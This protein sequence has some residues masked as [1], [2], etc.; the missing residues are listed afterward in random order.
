MQP[1]LICLH[2]CPIL[3]HVA[4]FEARAGGLGAGGRSSVLHVHDNVRTLPHDALCH[5]SST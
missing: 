3:W 5:F 2:L 4:R 1:E